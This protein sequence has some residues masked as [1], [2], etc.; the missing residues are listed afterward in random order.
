[1]SISEENEKLSQQLNPQ[2]V[3]RE[4]VGGNTFKKGAN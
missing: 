4:T 3:G 1:M 2:E